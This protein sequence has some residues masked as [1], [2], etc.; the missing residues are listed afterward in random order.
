MK[1]GQDICF[2]SLEQRIWFEVSSLSTRAPY[3]EQF[4]EYVQDIGM[5]VDEEEEEE[6]E[7]E[8]NNMKENQDQKNYLDLENNS[9][10]PFSGFRVDVADFVYLKSKQKTT[11]PSFVRRFL[12]Q[13]VEGN[14]D[15]LRNRMIHF[16]QCILEY[17]R[18]PELELWVLWK[19]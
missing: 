16:D 2:I 4:R 8:D 10:Q 7:Q 13:S 15:L 6:E 3:Y 17:K 12:C 5:E 18:V 11:I 1:I 19:N 9:D 14:E